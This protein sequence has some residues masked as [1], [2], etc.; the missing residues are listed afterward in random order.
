VL[1][2][3]QEALDGASPEAGLLL[4]A[5]GTLYGTTLFGGDSDDSGTVFS[6]SP[7]H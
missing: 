1:H 6:I 4:A 2:T 3:F 5:D 7:Q